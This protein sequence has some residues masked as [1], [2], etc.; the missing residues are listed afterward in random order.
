MLGIKKPA[1]SRYKGNN[2][3]D[4]SYV[5]CNTEVLGDI[6]FAGG[7]HVEGK[8]TGNIVS[9]DGSLH[10]HGEVI[11]EIHVPHIVIN[12]VVRGNVYAGEH[13][14]LASKAMVNGNVYYKSMEMMLGAQVNGSLL[15]SD[16]P[17]IQ[18][19]E[20]KPDVMAKEE[21]VVAKSPD[22]ANS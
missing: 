4:H 18:L 3:K 11:G 8:V 14:E 20:H 15:Y 22:T 1:G 17:Q 2:Y 19:I 10:V 12:G 7:L 6:K 5:A 13:I 21:A 9:E 16:K